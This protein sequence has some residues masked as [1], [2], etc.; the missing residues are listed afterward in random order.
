MQKKIDINMIFYKYRTDSNF[1]EQI[2]TKGQV[3]LATANELNDPFECSLQDIGKEWIEKKVAE[4]Q[5]A[6]VMGF[7][8]EANRSI[9]ERRE[10]FGLTIS[11]TKKMLQSIKKMGNVRDIYLL[12]SKVMKKYTGHEPADVEGLFA[13]IDSQLLSV[14]IFSMSTNSKHPLMWS[15][16]GGDHTGICLGFLKTPES[17]LSNPENLLPVIYSDKVPTL[18]GD[19]FQTIM[20]FSVDN[21]GRMYTSSY[22]LA[23][24]DKTLQKAISAKSMDWKYEEEW[25]YVEP[26][27]GVFDLPAP[28]HEIIFGLNCRDSRIYHYIKLA[29]E[30]IPYP[31][32]IFKMTRKPNTTEIARE[33]F[34]KPVTIPKILKSP[35]EK[36]NRDKD[37]MTWDEFNSKMERLIKQEKYGEVLYFVNENLMLT[38]NSPDLLHLKGVAHGFAQ[39]HDLALECFSKLN[40][41]FPEDAQCWYQ[42]ACALTALERHEDAVKALK[43]AFKLDKEN[44]SIC[45][46]LAIE[47]IKTYNDE[48]EVL[49]FL[50]LAHNLGHR[51]A[52]SIITQL[53]NEG[54]DSL[55]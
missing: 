5:G 20:S 16:Y 45:F 52:N 19:G 51:R 4:L 37:G 48:T 11:E 13:R 24:N 32:Q 14:G 39:E 30:N 54:I 27:G 29:E 38:P 28:L 23:F 1:T 2:I 31:I 44:A 43:A 41:D 7:V 17:R 42:T 18:E 47:L 34:E 21:N 50:R 9:K 25:R 22:K 33:L 3:Y 36:L 10:Y 26:F 12:R 46:N 49:R 53:E 55:Q 8:M 40:Q 35:I 6:G 15:H